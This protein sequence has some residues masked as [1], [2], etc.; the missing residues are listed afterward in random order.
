VYLVTVDGRQAPHSDGMTLAELATLM[1]AL[2]SHEAVNLDGGGSTAMVVGQGDTAFRVVNRPSDRGG[3][4][5]VG[6]AVGL[7]RRCR[8]P[9]AP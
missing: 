9:A 5:A 1:L 4:R 6:D 8:T 3:E 2:G 7:V